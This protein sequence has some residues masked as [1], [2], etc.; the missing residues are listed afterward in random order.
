[1]PCKYDTI[2]IIVQ[3]NEQNKERFPGAPTVGGWVLDNFPNSPNYWIPLA[4]KGLLPDTV[5]CL[6]NSADNGK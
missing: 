6:K 5:I 3:F 4:E 2:F 1:M